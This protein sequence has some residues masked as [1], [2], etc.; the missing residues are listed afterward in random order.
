V[1]AKN[2]DTGADRGVTTGSSGEYRLDELQPGTYM[3][4][5]EAKGF[6]TT[7]VPSV[8]LQVGDA[9]D[10]NV[11][12]KIAT[13]ANEVLVSEQADV[14]ETT[15]TDVSSTVSSKEVADLPTTTNFAGLGGVSNDYQGLATLAPGVH[16]DFTGNSGDLIGP[17]AVNSRGVLTNID[18]GD[19]NDMVGASRSALGASIDEVQEFQVLTNNYNAEYGQA[20]GVI[21]NLI[22]KSGTNDFH[23][24]GH[25][26][27]RG[28]N[29]EASNYFYNVTPDAQYRRAPF[30][31]REGGLTFGGPIIKNKTF[32]FSSYELTH[33]GSPTTLSPPTGIV[34][35]NQPTNE[36]LWSVKLD[37]Q[38]TSTNRISARYNVQRDTQENQIVQV[39]NYASPQSLVN[40][41]GHNESFNIG[42]VAT[43]TPNLVNEARFFWHRYLNQTPT[44]TTLPGELGSNFYYG[45]PFCCPQAALSDRY[46]YIDHLSWT[47]GTHTVR[48]GMDISHYPYHDLFQQYHY[49]EYG[50]FAAAAPNQG[51]PGYLTVGLGP[52]TINTSDNVYGFFVQDTWKV[53]PNLTVNYGLRWDM[54]DGAFKGGAVPKP[55][56]GCYQANG[57]VPACSSDKNNFQPRI[58]LAYSPRF[59]SGLLRKVFGE[60]DK[61]VFRAA[62]AETTMLAFLN[63]VEDSL[64]FDG[65]NLFTTT[66]TDPA[67]LAYFPNS[68]PTNVL[69]TY[70]PN[71]QTYFGRVRPIASNL[72]N[73]ESRNFN[74]TISRQLTNSTMVEVSY[75]GVFGFGLFGEQ[76]TNAPAILAD[77]AHPGYYY[78]GARPDSRFL[79]IR[80][81]ENSRTSSYNA[82]TVHAVK[83]YSAHLQFQASYV[84]SKTL[85]TA[86]D[87][88]GTSEPGDLNNIRAERG[89]TQS[90]IPNQ[91]NFGVVYDTGRLMRNRMAGAVTNNVVLSVI[92]QLQSG[93]PYPLSTGD[94]G[95]S[96]EI[97][98]GIGAETQ[99][100]PSIQADGTIVSTNI[101]S[102]NGTNLLISQAGHTACPACPQTTFLAPAGASPS[103]SKDSLTGNV[104]DFQYVNGNLA[105]DVPRG[106]PYYRFDLSAI[107]SF[108]IKDK[109]K[110]ELKADFFNVFNHTNFLLYNNLDTLN[111]FGLSTD[112]SC[113]SCLSAVTGR[114]IGADG[115]TLRIQNLMHGKVSK[116]VQRPLFAGVGDPATADIPRQIQLALRFRF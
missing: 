41:V 61:T 29:L 70:L 98:P 90:D 52:G 51:L 102:A 59:E 94:A 4:T 92:S 48:A 27:F 105:R 106:S 7:Q 23:G 36:L 28:R 13:Q 86:E 88:Y 101:A 84:R 17:G 72:K 21:I 97:F 1:N 60:Q 12:L 45:A 73:P 6:A 109:Y 53:K 34:T 81:N 96:S 57:I 19:I 50:G 25:I 11:N 18:G 3:V 111:N 58:G 38:L 76:D 14:I 43:L 35:V 56:G 75:L 22:T 15:K 93:R 114:Y 91:G 113:T 31:K 62:F 83:R 107:K 80:T 10:V 69:A 64:N 9:R 82:F 32:F 5:V 100:R 26:Y 77:A 103:G 116:S 87:F 74:F 24:D 55:G 33:Q 40:V 8:L 2:R 54:E 68:P 110:V 20:G 79:A 30:Y 46:Q 89:V 85:S 67:V 78:Y 112:A 44:Q 42:D 99:Q 47:K 115:S 108:T 16:Y 71:P 65:K 66:I 63:I 37:H 49:G 39:P 95:F 104:V